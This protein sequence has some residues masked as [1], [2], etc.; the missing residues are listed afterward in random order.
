M[1]LYFN[2]IILVLGLTYNATIQCHAHFRELCEITRGWN[3]TSTRFTQA[4]VPDA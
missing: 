1:A 2:P 3:S 4:A